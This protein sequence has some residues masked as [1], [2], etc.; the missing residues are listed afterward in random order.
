[1]TDGDPRSLWDPLAGWW[2]Q[3]FTDGADPEYDRQILPLVTSELAGARRVLD[4]GCGE[5]QVTR[6]LLTASRA[7]TGAVAAGADRAGAP[8]RS[9]AAGA[10]RLGMTRAVGLDP[11]RAQLANALAAGAGTQAGAARGRVAPSYVQGRGEQLPFAGSSFDAVV[12][13]LA[14]EHTNDVDAVLAE[15][16]RVLEPGGQFLLLV[17][18][19]MFQGTGSG[20]ID[21][22]ILGERYWRV[23]LAE[24]DVLLVHMEEPPPHPDFLATS[25]DPELEG[26]I[27]RL[28]AM[29]FERRPRAAAIG[30][31]GRSVSSNGDR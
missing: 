23:G 16:A 2:K 1:M 9:P 22:R 31:D 28:L 5:G 7:A 29:R 25:V 24:R 30:Q 3:T 4:L 12:C 13:C 20:F 21:D 27:P 18:H 10:A 17:N 6:A 8:R 14:I 19:P 11:S 15:V 26:A